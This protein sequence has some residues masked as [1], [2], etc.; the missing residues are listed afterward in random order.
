[1]RTSVTTKD[2]KMTAAAEKQTPRSQPSAAD[3]HA[4]LV[5]ANLKAK[6]QFA[7]R[8]EGASIRLKTTLHNRPVIR[9]FKRIFNTGMRNWYIATSVPRASLGDSSLAAQV[10]AGML[11]K[12]GETITH[13]KQK[14]SQ[15]DVVAR[16][17]NV[18]F[19]L[20]S[21]GAEFAD[22]TRVIGPV[23]M[24][25]RELFLV[26]DRFLDLQQALYAFEQVSGDEANNASYDVKKRLEAVATSIRNFRRLALEK[27][28]DSGKNRQGFK[29]V[30][31]DEEAGQAEVIALSTPA[32]TAS[33]VTEISSASVIAPPTVDL[34]STEA[35]TVA[36]VAE[37]VTVEPK[38][39]RK[40]A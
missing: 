11:K 10:E 32:D 2:P 29:A 14:V 17:A 6:I 8:Y 15:C 33:N 13:F 27:V 3:R 40:A 39:S 12:V 5:A 34:V 1:M 22:D 7:D 23:A 9:S 36:A 31:I 19:S 35:A 25:L 20:I 26:T 28:N 4:T 16:D 24:Q 37:D 21:H 18:D 38:K 30:V